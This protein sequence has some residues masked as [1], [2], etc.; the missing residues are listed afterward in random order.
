MTSVSW[1]EFEAGAPELA[2]FGAERLHGQVSYL[3]TIRKNKLPRLH[4][5]T[6]IIG[7]GHLF[8]FMEP[9]SPKGR[10]LERGSAYV[11]HSGVADNLGSN[12]EFQL[13]GYGSRADEATARQQAVSFSADAKLEQPEDR[14]ILFEF[15]VIEALSTVY[16]DDESVFTRWKVPA[17]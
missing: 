10:D 5:V 6:P 9:T 4:P 11:L 17:P 15:G 2:R 13:T 14:H 8:V 16:R 3:A 1:K 12:G 7:G